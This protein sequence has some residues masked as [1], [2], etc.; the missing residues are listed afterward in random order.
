MHIRPSPRVRTIIVRAWGRGVV[1][2]QSIA[3][4]PRSAPP[5]WSIVR[6]S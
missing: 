4:A 1:M 3:G 6:A 5:R 2:A